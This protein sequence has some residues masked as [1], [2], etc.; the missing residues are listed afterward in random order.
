MKERVILVLVDGMRPDGML[1][2][3]NPFVQELMA[4]SSYCLQAKTVMPS[5]TLPCHMSLFHS[6]DPDR[7]GVTTNTYT[8]QVRPIDGLFEQLKHA[9]KLT[10]MFYT[11]HQLRDVAR[12]G[13]VGVST[14]INL[15][16]YTEADDK[17]TAAFLPYV[18]ET[19]LP[20]FTFLYLG[21]T[22][23]TGHR[24]GWMGAEYEAAIDN[25]FSCIKRVYEAMPAD[26]TL[27]VIADHGGHTRGHGTDMPED[28]T[29][30]V[31]L[32]GKHFAAGR[33]LADVNIKDIA[34]TVAA[35]LDTPTADEWEGRSLLA[36][37]EC[38]G[39]TCC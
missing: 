25:A 9:K 22:D 19:A 24:H 37:G 11:W 13:S 28:M 38:Y 8:P 15:H 12:P 21:D 34:P 23:E 30:P 6:V 35:I 3:G 31:I 7:H 18:T 32:C 27:I 14:L 17:I 33:E 16:N 29:I 5:V 26:T 39:A 2:C 4:R 20:D 1:Q 10:G 36:A